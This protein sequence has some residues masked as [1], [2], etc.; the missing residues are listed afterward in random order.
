[1]R[2]RTP[3]DVGALIRTRKKL[4]LDQRREKPRAKSVFPIRNDGDCF[5]SSAS[6]LRKRLAGKHHRGH[7]QPKVPAVSTP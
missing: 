1:M 6:I 2:I 5:Q 4:G 3:A 7:S